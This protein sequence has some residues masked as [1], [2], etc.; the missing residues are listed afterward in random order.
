MVRRFTGQR[1]VES[2]R[3]TREILLTKKGGI[4]IFSKKGGGKKE[5]S[6]GL[7]V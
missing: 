4:N 5:A 2:N 1:R 6:G 3:L 7:K